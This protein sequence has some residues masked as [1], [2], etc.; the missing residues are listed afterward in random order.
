MSNM[1]LKYINPVFIETG[2]F[3][4]SGISLAIDAGFKKIISI[5]SKIEYYEECIKKFSK[6]IEEGRVKIILGKSEECLKDILST[7]DC[8]ATFWLDAHPTSVENKSISTF[9]L[10]QE[11]EFICNHKV[12]S[13]TILIDD[14]RHFVYMNTTK[15]WIVDTILKNNKNYEISFD[16]MRESL[17]S[18][19]LVAKL[20]DIKIKTTPWLNKDAVS[21]LQ[22]YLK[23]NNHPKILEFGV[24]G[25]TIWFSQ[26][27][28]NLITVEH[29][30]NWLDLTEDYI[31]ND[32]KNHHYNVSYFLRDRPYDC[33]CD[34]FVDNY[35]DFI[36]IDGRDRIKC[37]QKCIRILKTGGIIMLDDAERIRYQC[38]YKM[39]IDWKLNKSSQMQGDYERQTNWW[40][41]P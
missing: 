36:L 40:I 18:D 30:K 26:Y 23:A 10:K 19:V 38:A 3:H 29:D 31:Q 1:F 17:I 15:D 14:V 6:F 13:H 9:P 4:G 33:V 32:T 8:P 24:G 27:T 28:K 25:T 16:T 22:D 2:T 11:I 35:F 5:E 37:L 21:F 41:K 20:K 39:L 12:K 7:I 34:M